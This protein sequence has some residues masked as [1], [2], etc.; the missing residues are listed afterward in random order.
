[1]LNARSALHKMRQFP[2]FLQ[3]QFLLL[4]YNTIFLFCQ[5]KRFQGV[6]FVYFILFLAIFSHSALFFRIFS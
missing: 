3:L 5:F 4:T 1:M 2:T 6:A